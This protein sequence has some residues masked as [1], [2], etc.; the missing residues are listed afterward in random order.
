MG[1]YDSALSNWL[2][3]QKASKKGFQAAESPLMDMAKEFAPGGTYEQGQFGIINQEGKQAAAGGLANLAATGMSS[4]SLGVGLRSRIGKDMA[5]AK[6]GV[7]GSRIANLSE[8]LK[9]L[10]GLRE[11]AASQIGQTYNPFANTEIDAE[12]AAANRQDQLA[13]FNVKQ[14]NQ[15]AASQKN[16]FDEM[17]PS[18]MAPK[19]KTPVGGTSPSLDFSLPG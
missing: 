15:T 11:S 9:S 12:S 17:F 13:M 19:P 4:G 18:Q 3:N 10:S 6:T 1:A 7:E 8:V 16:T 5:I 2:A 14:F